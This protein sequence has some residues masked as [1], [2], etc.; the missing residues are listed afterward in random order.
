M[1]NNSLLVAKILGLSL[2]H[3]VS[4][5]L[6]A[7]VI[8]L[9]IGFENQ[10]E[11]NVQWLTMLTVSLLETIAMVWLVSFLK[12]HGLRL[13]L[14]AV[15]VFHSTKVFMM[16]IE[17]AFFLN[18]W[19][20]TPI[21]SMSEVWTNELLGLLMA[22]IYCP[23]LVW[24][25]GKWRSENT[26]ERMQYFS[27]PKLIL[28]KRLTAVSVVYTICYLLAGAL[29]LMP[30]AGDAFEPTYATLQVPAWMPLFQIARGL[31]WGLILLP[32][33]M[34][35]SGSTRHL[36]MGSGL[37]LAALGAAQLLYP[38]PYMVEHLRYAHLLE[39]VVSMFVFGWI[40]SAILGRQIK[41]TAD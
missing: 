19:T 16:L 36:K 39:I 26:A 3:M 31:L 21:M 35:F 8:N 38:N 13:V 23:L 17:A 25:M 18:I 20:T 34:Y 29:M 30:L 41:T 14:V 9:T 24:L 10:G 5:M 32:V 2:W 22:L 37:L 12:L 40:A 4:L 27:I 6:A 33:V 1:Q 15:L 28:V 11:Q 7:M